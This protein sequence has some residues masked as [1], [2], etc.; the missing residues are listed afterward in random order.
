MSDG[1]QRNTSEGRGRRAGRTPAEWTTLAISVA[2]V[3]AVVALLVYEGVTSAEGEPVT[4]RVTPLLDEV[5]RQED[6]Y[7]M[8]VEVRNTSDRTA[9]HVRVRV[10]LTGAGAQTS[11]TQRAGDPAG[12]FEVQFLAGGESFRAVVV[13]NQ[14]PS[15]GQLESRVISFHAP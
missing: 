12:Q 13:L 4:F 9:E 15:Q 6:L 8:P 11:Q 2:V 3:L 5:H 14:D 7:Y 10:R 1:D